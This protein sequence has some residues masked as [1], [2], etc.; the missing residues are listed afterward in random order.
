MRKKEIFTEAQKEVRR[1]RALEWIKNNPEKARQ[2]A[3][4]YRARNRERIALQAKE[5]QKGNRGACVS[6]QRRWTAKYP[7]Y[8]IWQGA[9]Q[10]CSNPKHPA[11]HR[12]GG[13]GIKFLLSRADMSFLWNRDEA[14]KLSKPS[15]DRRNNDGDYVL[16]NCAFIEKSDNTRK[17]WGIIAG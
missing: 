2:N 1:K 14:W 16:S 15:I 3:R 12:Y 10:R 17:R 11:Y 8:Y 9:R 13:R 6:A 5:W 4:L 7:W